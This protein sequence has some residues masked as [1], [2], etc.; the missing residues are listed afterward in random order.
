MRARHAHAGGLIL[1]ALVVLAQP[2]GLTA[3]DTKHDLAA[4]PAGFLAGALHAYTDTF[5]LGQLQNQAYGY[6][7]PM[8]SLFLAGDAVGMPAWVTQRVW[9]MLLLVVSFVGAERVARRL[10]GLTTVPALLVGMVFALSPRVLT[11]LSEI[12]VEV[13]PQALAPWLLL[14]ALAVALLALG[15]DRILGAH[16]IG[17]QAS[18]LLQSFITMMN[19]GIGARQM[20]RGQYWIHPALT[21]VVEN[22]LLGLAERAEQAD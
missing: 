7:W 4:N 5:T 15:A 6:L 2:W 22:A 3:A 8:G 13:W 1:V 20:A 16:V 18:I 10:A 12:S 19:L 11:V 14:A 9:W 17:P 21:E